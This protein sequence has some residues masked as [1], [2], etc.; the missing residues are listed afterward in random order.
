MALKTLGTETSVRTSF[1]GEA[2]RGLRFVFSYPHSV[3]EFVWSVLAL[4]GR[5]HVWLIAYYER[6]FKKKSY[7]D[8]WREEL[9]IST[10]TLD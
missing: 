7:Q 8:G 9:T 5:L 4:F 2:F 3:K 6:L 1:F 10:R